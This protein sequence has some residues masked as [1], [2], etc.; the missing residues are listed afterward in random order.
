MNK[1]IQDPDLLDLAV[2]GIQ[3]YLMLLTEF[4]DT[5]KPKLSDLVK[6]P[7]GLIGVITGFEMPVPPNEQ[8]RYAV[9]VPNTDDPLSSGIQWLDGDEVEFIPQWF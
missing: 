5:R 1:I 8:W 6:L 9:Y 3:N 2:D 7:S 4:S